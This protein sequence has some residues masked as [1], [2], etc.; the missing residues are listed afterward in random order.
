MFHLLPCLRYLNSLNGQ[1]SAVSS[2]SA[3]PYASTIIFISLLSNDSVYV[4]LLSPYK[5]SQSWFYFFIDQLINQLFYIQLY[6]KVDVIFICLFILNIAHLYMRLVLTFPLLIEYSFQSTP[7]P[8][9][10]PKGTPPLINKLKNLKKVP[11][12]TITSKIMVHHQHH[13]SFLT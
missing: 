5:I 3:M 7:P 6:P 12:T 2:I 8:P 9:P 4:L 1:M 10:P 11:P 13:S